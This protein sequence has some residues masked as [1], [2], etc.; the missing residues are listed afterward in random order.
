[1][2]RN[3][4][5]TLIELLVVIAII[6]ILAAIL[7]PVFAKVREK[8]RQTA[9]LSN[10]R[11][12]GLALIQYV[13]DNDQCTPSCAPGGAN[14]A[15]AGWASRIL[16]YVGTPS[17]YQCPDDSSITTA[18]GQIGTS[19]ALNA[20]TIVEDQQG[21]G[22][23]FSQSAYTEPDKTVWFFEIAGAT[24]EVITNPAVT[25]TY[26]FGDWT[27]G[28]QSPVGWGIGET[29]NSN[30]PY[31]ANAQNGA[32]SSQTDGHLQYVTGQFGYS[33]VCNNFL[34]TP[35]HTGGSNYLLADGHAKWFRGAAI[36]GGEDNPTVGSPGGTANCVNGPNFSN[37][38]T[39]MCAANTSAVGTGNTFGATF[40][41]H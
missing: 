4:G 25:A 11:Q 36:A 29:A 40:S 22:R 41:I 17:L 30:D 7:F 14:N 33:T 32:T 34:T 37:A 15:P 9:C 24:G 21:T 1:M 19:Y 13:N 18:N 31:G 35:R 38:L 8:A 12:L 10:I 23:S 16:P 27:F 2:Q 28:G 5:F 26:P 3:K 6:A 20:D 39:F